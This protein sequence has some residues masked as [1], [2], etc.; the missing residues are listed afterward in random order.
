MDMTGQYRIPAAR[1][2]VWELLNDPEVLAK[3]IP[4]CEQLT[5]LSAEELEARVKAKAAAMATSTPSS[6]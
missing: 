5:R 4:G 6:A 1:Q 3:A 2:R